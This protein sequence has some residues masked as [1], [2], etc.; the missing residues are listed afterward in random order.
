ADFSEPYAVPLG[1]ALQLIVFDS[2][3]AGNVPLKKDNAKDELTR[4]TYLSQL[5]AVTALAA[6]PG[7]NSWFASH[8]PV[9]AFAPDPWHPGAIFAGNPALQHSL[10]EVNGEA[11]FAPGV[12]LAL[13]GH[14]HLF[15]ALRFESNHAPTLVAGHGGD[16]LDIDLPIAAV[17]SASPAPGVRV[18]QITHSSSFGFLMLQRVSGD[19]DEWSVTAFR[20]DGSVLT[21]CALTHDGALG[22]T[23]DGWLR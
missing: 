20:T 17:Q 7:R 10:R 5:R 6:A 9:L 8:H 11:Y 22:C 4:S 12:R 19:S 23:P 21:R 15:E 16:D 18:G 14:V 1:R 13:H 2:A 3:R